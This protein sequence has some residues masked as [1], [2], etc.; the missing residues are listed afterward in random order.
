M[1]GD[2]YAIRTEG[3][4]KEYGDVVAMLALSIVL[5]RRM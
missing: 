4:R 3:L 1:E 5:M 2:G